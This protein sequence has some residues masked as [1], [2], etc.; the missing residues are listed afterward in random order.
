MRDMGPAG[1]FEA[2]KRGDMIEIEAILEDRPSWVRAVDRSGR[3]L[4]YWATLSGYNQRTTSFVAVVQ[5]LLDAGA[6]VDIF[7]A[8]WLGWDFAVRDLLGRDQGLAVALDRERMS[9]LHH[10]AERGSSDV[11]QLLLD[12]GAD[13]NSRDLLGQSPLD[14][15]AS[16]GPW[17]DGPAESCIRLL[18]ACGAEMDVFLAARL[19]RLDRLTVE[20]VAAAALDR[21][22]MTPLHHAARCGQPDAVVALLEAGVP[23][24]ACTPQGRTALMEAILGWG[25]SGVDTAATELILRGASVDARDRLGRTA[26]GYARAHGHLDAV[27]LL[28]AHDAKL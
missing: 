9:P 14:H 5:L 21:R 1:L 8:T 4:L 18:E 20:R 6:L 25:P 11:V 2:V 15:A 3:P 24:D 26:L 22:G 12:A 27:V 16:I 23:V 28:G 10:A 19:G 7:A 17:K 13:A